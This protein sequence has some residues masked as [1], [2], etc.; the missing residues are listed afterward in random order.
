MSLDKT[1][2]RMHYTG[3]MIT[4]YGRP[5][6]DPAWAG[7]LSASD[8]VFKNKQDENEG[9]LVALNE[10]GVTQRGCTLMHNGKEDKAHWRCKFYLGHE[11]RIIAKGTLFQC[12]KFYDYAL[13]HFE[14]YRV[15]K[16]SIYNRFN[17]NP[18]DDKAEMTYAPGIAA[19]L[20]TLEKHLL[21]FGDLTP[22]GTRK[23]EQYFNRRATQRTWRKKQTGTYQVLEGIRENTEGLVFLNSEM[24][25]IQKQFVEVHKKLDEIRRV[26][27]TRH[28]IV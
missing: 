19:Y 15:K 27:Q 26:M 23:D 20:E 28:D 25:A 5:S 2:L 1:A 18:E 6:R 7:L 21:S 8:A 14:K 22:P 3:D 12:A 17:F 24:A 9:M 13:I 11:Q 4:Q 10:D 16:D